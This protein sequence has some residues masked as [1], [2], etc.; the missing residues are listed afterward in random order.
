VKTTQG[1]TPIKADGKLLVIDGG[2][3]KA[4]QEETGIA[5]YT[6]IFNSHGLKLVQHHP[7]ESAE[8]AALLGK[9]IIS[10]TSVVDFVSNRMLVKD[11]DNGKR[12][13]AQVDDLKKLLEAYRSG[14]VRQRG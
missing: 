13:R 6:L 3:S 11:T 2:F 8:S 12:L 14:K 10:T 4:Y 9:D 7:F 5:G 1:E